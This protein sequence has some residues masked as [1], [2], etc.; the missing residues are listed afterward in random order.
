MRSICKVRLMKHVLSG[1]RDDVARGRFGVRGGRL[2]RDHS[3]CSRNSGASAAF[4]FDNSYAYAVF[5]TVG[6]GPPLFVGG[7]HTAKGPCLRPMAKWDGNVTID[8]QL[9]V[10][11]QGGR[12][13]LQPDYLLSKIKRAL[14]EFRSGSFEFGA[15]ASVVAITA[16]CFGQRRDHRCRW[17]PA[18]RRKETT[19]TTRGKY[20][21]GHGD[22]RDRQGRPHGDR[23]AVRR[24]EVQVL[25]AR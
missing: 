16:G 9:S 8:R 25:A 2:S 1:V 3:P 20:V 21:K 22:L 6:E 4:P 13:G 14:D 12:Q 7:R 19:R 15:D 18:R 10:G 5:P 11:L 17:P 23:W 24:G